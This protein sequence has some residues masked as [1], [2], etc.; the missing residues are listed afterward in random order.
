MGKSGSKFDYGNAE[1]STA[2]DE[3]HHEIGK[4]H[5]GILLAAFQCD[6]IR[7]GTFQWSPGTNHVSFKGLFPGEP[8]SIYMHHPLSHE[9]NGLPRSQFFE[10]PHPDQGKQ[11]IV[12]F[13]A[14]VQTW[15]N[16]KTAE[17]ISMFKNATDAF[18][19]NMLD[20]TVIP[21]VTEVAEQNHGRN[22]KAAFIFGGKSL[23]MQG[24]STS[25]SKVRSGPTSTSGRRW[26]RRTFRAMTPC[27]TSGITS[28]Q[29]NPSP[30]DG[31]W[32][33]V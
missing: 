21:F 17:I 25:T 30:I 16:E 12:E 33:P 31:L 13:L 4:L 9:L 3:I 20:S 32:V 23:G 29:S 24:A 5:A 7:V 27:S 26:R 10:G 2:D 28:L 22:T 14:N 11:D 18:G 8:N 1:T 15:Y 6:I 19:G